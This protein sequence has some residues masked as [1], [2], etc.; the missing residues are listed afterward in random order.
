[1]RTKIVPSET[2]ITNAAGAILPLLEKESSHE[3]HL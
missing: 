3:S 1:M 2:E